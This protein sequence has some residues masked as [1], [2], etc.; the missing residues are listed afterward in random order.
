LS[1]Y[2]A[3]YAHPAYGVITIRE[4]DGALHWS[5]CGMGALLSHRHF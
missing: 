1:A 3:D 4:R 2:A 5:W